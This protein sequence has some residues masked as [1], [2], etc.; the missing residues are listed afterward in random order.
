MQKTYSPEPVLAQ[1]NMATKK[2]ECLV[3]GIQPIP[4]RLSVLEA[5]G[6][7]LGSTGHLA[8]PA[9]NAS[10]QIYD[11]LMGR[12]VASLQVLQTP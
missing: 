3:Q 10:L 4:R 1:V 2:V 5:G 8:L 9:S 11:P 7:L 6:Q 12:H